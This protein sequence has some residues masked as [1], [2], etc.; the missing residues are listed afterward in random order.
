MS[1]I[2]KDCFEGRKEDRASAGIKVSGQRGRVGEGFDFDGEGG[3]LFPP[4]VSLQHF[5]EMKKGGWDRI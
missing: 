3:F 5:M 2:L 4:Y 1:H